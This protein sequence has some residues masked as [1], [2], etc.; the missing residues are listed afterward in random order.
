M[1]WRSRA[2]HAYEQGGAFDGAV[3]EGERQGAF[4][5]PDGARWHDIQHRADDLTE[6]LYILR[7]T[8][9]TGRRRA[10]VADALASLQAVRY[11]LDAQRAPDGA[12]AQQNGTLH[13]RLIALESLLN[14][15]PDAG[16]SPWVN[17]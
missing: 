11:G 4:L 8:A 14:R 3:R 12:G 17:L 5:D 2:S 1:N 6:A 13:S 7:E 16:R 10:Q 9:P 15:A